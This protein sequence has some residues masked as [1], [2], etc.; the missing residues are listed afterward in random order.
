MKTKKNGLQRFTKFEIKKQSLF[1]LKIITASD[2]EILNKSERIKFFEDI[3][4][5]LNSLEGTKRDDFLKQIDQLISHETRNR[6]WEFNHSKI[7][8]AIANLIE[9]F[10]NM[11]S[12]VDIAS[13]TGLSRVTIDKH[14]REYSNSHLY[15][16][17][18]EQF[19]YM[20][21]KV[22]AKVFSFAMN[23]NIGACR[24]F[25]ETLGITGLKNEKTKICNQNN[26]IQ[27]N[28]LTINQ[29][30]IMQ[31]KPEQLKQIETILKCNPEN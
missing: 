27:I 10:G 18:I 14:L 29:Q 24:L 4:Y 9:E 25:L 1:S 3:T 2:L 15:D 6:I 17:E 28:G 31:L 7:S 5:K 30:Q 8:I 19:K 11:P 23:G 20:T 12:K 22:L 16:Q 13:K 21:P 26:F